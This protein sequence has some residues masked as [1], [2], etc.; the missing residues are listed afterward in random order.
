MFSKIGIK[1]VREVDVDGIG[2]LFCVVSWEVYQNGR[3][4]SVASSHAEAYAV[5]RLLEARD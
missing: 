2:Q 5:A 4:V 3:L 1:E